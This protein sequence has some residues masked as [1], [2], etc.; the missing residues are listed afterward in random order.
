MLKPKNAL[1]YRYNLITV[2]GGISIF[3]FITLIDYIIIVI[4]LL[5]IIIYYILINF[6]TNRTNETNNVVSNDNKKIHK[7]N[8]DLNNKWLQSPIKVTLEYSIID[9]SNVGKNKVKIKNAIELFVLYDYNFTIV[10]DCKY[11]LSINYSNS[12][13]LDVLI[14]NICNKI[15]SHTIS[16]GALLHKLF[17]ETIDKNTRWEFY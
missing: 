4:P 1:L 16:R 2:F 13:E 10:D 8:S 14:S 9:N 12:D 5:V 6:N 3:I 11:N 17:I 7:I 15:T